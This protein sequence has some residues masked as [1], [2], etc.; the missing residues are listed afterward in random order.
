MIRRFALMVLLSMMLAS[1]T[2]AQTGVPDTNPPATIRAAEEEGAAFPR[3]KAQTLPPTFKDGETAGTADRKCV[4]FPEGLEV[5]SRR[6]GDFVVGG[7]IPNLSAGREGK[8][9]WAPMHDPAGSKAT[10][11]V[12]SARLDQPTITSRFTSSHYA[13]PVAA[14]WSVLRDHAF[15][16]SGFSL[17]TPGR[18]LLAVTSGDDWG[19]FI[20]SVRP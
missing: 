14:D 2:R 9:W 15:Y 16:P 5:G 11:V 20:V 6:S 10:L 18:W 4:E 12:R 8:V 17:P 13:W 1:F 7:S 3:S 19:C